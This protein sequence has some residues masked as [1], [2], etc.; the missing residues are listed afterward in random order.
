MTH[1]WHA[2]SLLFLARVRE[3]YRQPSVLLWAYGFPLFLAI[4][5]GYAFSGGAPT[6]TG[7]ES[8]APAPPAAGGGPA[9]RYVDF[10][11]PGL[12]GLNLMSGCLWGVGFVIVDLRVRKLLKRLVATPMRRSDFLLAIVSSRL[13]LLVPEMLLLAL[14][15]VVAFGMPMRGHAGTLALVVLAGGAAF[16]G[17]GLLAACRLERT[18][19]MTGVINLVM[20]PMWMLSGTF[21]SPDRFPA[22]LRPVSR[23]LPLTPV[24]DALRQV[25]LEGAGL[26]Q[27][28]RA[29]AVLAGWAAACF[30]LAVAWFRWR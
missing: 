13:L 4:G 26:A 14:V 19:T 8:R 12:M 21:F 24:N 7:L 15:G 18:E 28:A 3:F 22:A 5:L 20:L 6:A 27:V 29:L 25:I 10:L 23:A 9:G 1:R 30:L 2:F 11:I 16:A 17:L